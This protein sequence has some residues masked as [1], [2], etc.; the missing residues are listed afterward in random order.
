[1]YIRTATKCTE[2]IRTVRMYLTYGSTPVVSSMQ[3]DRSGVCFYQSQ[4]GCAANKVGGVSV[5][6]MFNN[7]LTSPTKL[8][9]WF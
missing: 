1:M 3:Q 6:A 7:N 9:V 5:A 2:Y 8:W 4:D